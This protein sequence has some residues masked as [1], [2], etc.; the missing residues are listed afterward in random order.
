MKTTYIPYNNNLLFSQDR[1]RFVN[2]QSIKMWEVQ[3]GFPGENGQPAPWFI[4][5]CSQAASRTNNGLIM[6]V[7]ATE[8]FAVET[9]GNLHSFISAGDVH[10]WKWPPDLSGSPFEER[11]TRGYTAPYPDRDTHRET[12]EMVGDMRGDAREN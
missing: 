2:V 6:A 9:L 5:A 12:G 7:Y 11:R 10:L 8:R 3:E 1:R 4:V